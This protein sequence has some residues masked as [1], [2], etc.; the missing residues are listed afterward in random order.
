MEDNKKL[1]FMLGLA[2]KSGQIIVGAP[3]IIEHIQKKKTLDPETFLVIEAADTGE[4]SHKK[5]M[6]KCN[7]YNVRRIQINATCEE[8]GASLGKSATAAVAIVGKDMC[9]GVESKI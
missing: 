4:S 6:D 8:L 5:L 1:L 2:K 9:R 7:F 3:M